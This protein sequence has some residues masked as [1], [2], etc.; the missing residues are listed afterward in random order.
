MGRSP[1]RQSMGSPN[2][3]LRAS[4]MGTTSASTGAAAGADSRFLR[5]ALLRLLL[6]R[7]MAGAER[8]GPREHH[9]GVLAPVAD[10][11]ALAVV[12]R[13]FPKALL[14][15]L[16]EAAFE[17]LITDGRCQG[18]IAVEVVVVGGVVARVEKDRAEHGF[19]GVGEQRFEAAAASF[20]NAL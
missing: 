9:R 1:P 5:G 11:R 8:F 17:V 12:H 10:A 15:D 2:W 18:A 20:G 4:G 14:R 13:S 7:A 6:A 19:E 3:R 16:L